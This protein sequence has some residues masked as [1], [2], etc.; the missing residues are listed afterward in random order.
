VY[1]RKG[2]PIE[3][4]RLICSWAAVTG[5]LTVAS[6]WLPGLPADRLDLLR[7]AWPNHPLKPRPVDLF[8]QDLPRVWHLAWECSG[9]RR[10]LVGLFNWDGEKAARFALPA[11]RIGLPEAKAYVGF[12]CWADRFL[13][14][15][16]GTLEA[17]VPPGACRVLAVR[18]AADHPQVVSTSRHITQGVVDLVAEAWDAGAKTLAG[19]SRVVAGDPYEVRIVAGDDGEAWTA[20]KAELVGAPKG[21]TVSVTQDGGHV[22]LAIASP[23]TGEVRWRVPFGQ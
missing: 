20:G 17:E 4:A 16:E 18:P 3:H 15:F 14:P 7:R 11:G 12:D 19:T 22:R 6:D 23:E 13:E 10:D 1:V 8:E 5:Q 2:M 9:A 21:A